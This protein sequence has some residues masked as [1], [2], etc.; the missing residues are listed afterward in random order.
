MDQMV[1][2][3]FRRMDG[4]HAGGGAGFGGADIVHP[5]DKPLQA[6][7]ADCLRRQLI[8]AGAS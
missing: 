5:W 1:I 8:N 3:I 6:V 7:L 4:N 2:L